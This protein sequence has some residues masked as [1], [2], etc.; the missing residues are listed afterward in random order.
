[1][2]DAKLLADFRTGN[3]TVIVALRDYEKYLKTD[4]LA[5]L[6]RRFS[7]GAGQLRQETAV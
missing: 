3:D 7:S 4:V 6:G 5:A 1:V 2:T